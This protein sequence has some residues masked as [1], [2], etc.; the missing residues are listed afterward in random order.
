[1]R[2]SEGGYTYFVPDV[3]YH[4][5][6][7]RR[8]FERVINEQGSDHHSTITRVRAGLQALDAGIPKGWPDYVLHQMVTVLK[9]GEEVKIS[10]RAGSYVTLRDLI[11]EVGCDAT[12][13]FL[14]ARH[15]DSQL[16]FDIDLAKSQS[17][18]NPVYYIQ[19][20]HARICAVLAQWG[21]ERNSLS[22]EDVCVLDSDYEKQ[23]LQRMIDF[24]QVIE[25]AAEDLAP[26]LIAFYLKELAA[27]FHSYYN[28]SRFLVEDEKTKL[29]RLALIAAVAQV[30]KNGL[31]LLGVSAPEKM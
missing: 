22:Q 20:A 28:A 19:Y 1:M 5:D 18:D 10:K 31:A 26:H 24:P 14:A 11:D 27:D 17:N 4:L 23:L 12:R 3:A 8:G 15:P 9:N 2:K 7:W 30:L 16:V 21:G 13:F 25:T 29:A 6:K